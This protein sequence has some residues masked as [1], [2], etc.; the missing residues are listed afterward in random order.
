MTNDSWA[1]YA[2]CAYVVFFVV[3]ATGIFM[4]KVKR[5]SGRTP[6]AFKLLRGPG[7][8]LRR[9]I[10]KFEED[11]AFRLL[12]AALVPLGAAVAVLWAIVRLFQVTSPTALGIVL[13]ISAVIFVGGFVMIQRWALRDLT[14][15]RNDR[16]GYLGER[17]VAEHLEP[18][19]SRGYRVFHDVP[20]EGDT[21]GFNLDHVAVGPNG[22]ASI[23][24]KTRRKGRARAGT[25]EHVVI[26]DGR[27]LIWPWGEEG[28]EVQQAIG[29]AEW[30]KKFILQRTGIAT[31][32]M[33][34]LAIP[35]WWVETTARG[36]VTV[37]N[38]KTV[39]NA[40]EGRG[41]RILSDEQV[42]LIARQLDERCRD[43]ED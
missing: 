36:T 9:R 16:L 33:P 24:T 3:A 25:K 39:A 31:N 8:S 37:T 7:E 22:V 20:A 18:L 29:Q 34:V 11:G 19:L 38:S 43:V 26:Y 10:A 1:L 28:R 27:Q 30:L 35:G 13:A 23:E 32:V 40:A 5:R 14:R 2:V 6:V 12:G 4:W 41:P 17:D 21:S 15:Y 42:D